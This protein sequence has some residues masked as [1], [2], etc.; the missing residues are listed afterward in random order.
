MVLNAALRQALLRARV[1]RKNH[2]YFLG[3]GIDGTHQLA[4]LFRG[5][6]I[7]WAMQGQHREALPGIA[8]VRAVF[9]A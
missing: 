8:S 4:Q 6:D 1:R 2:R 7:G 9:E 3:H 5:I